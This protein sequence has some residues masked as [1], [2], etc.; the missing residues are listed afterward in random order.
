MRKKSVIKEYDMV[1][2]IATLLVIIGHSNFWD[3]VT[4][5]YGGISYQTNLLAIGEY[6]PIAHKIIGIMIAMIYSFHMPLFIALSGALFKIQISQY[7]EQNFGLLVRKKAK[8]LIVPFVLVNSF[9]AIPLKAIVHYFHG[10]N[11][12]K[13]IFIGQYLLQGNTHLWYLPSLF[14]IFFVMSVVETKVPGKFITK[15][16]AYFMLNIFS[17]LIEISLL[18]YVLRYCLWFYVGF[19]FENIRG[20]VNRRINIRNATKCCAV[21]LV[22]FFLKRLIEHYSINMIIIK[23]IICI[24]EIILALIGCFTCYGIC[25]LLGRNYRIINSKSYRVLLKNSYE[26]Y[27]YSDS[28]NYVILYIFFMCKGYAGFSSNIMAVVLFGIRIIF[29]AIGALL[30]NWIVRK[31][32]NIIIKRK[33]VNCKY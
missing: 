23:I 25:Y 10:T 7:Q 14:L 9:Y 27:L 3:I 30:V 28:I 21:F 12:F 1:R 6:E 13:S 11:Y 18:E 4:N 24:I 17:H 33:F 8:R 29:S 26:L 20:Y 19:C 5:G 31:I 15:L 2:V 32:K 16:I 22:I